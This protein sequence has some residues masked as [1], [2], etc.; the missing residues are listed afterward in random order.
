MGYHI[1]LCSASDYN[2][3][4][5]LLNSTYIRYRILMVLRIL[6]S[7]DGKQPWHSVSPQI[8]DHL[9]PALAIRF[10]CSSC[11]TALQVSLICWLFTRLIA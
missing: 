7:V 9:I 5:F 4:H 6:Q 10:G 8:S 2:A 3:S 1:K 11:W